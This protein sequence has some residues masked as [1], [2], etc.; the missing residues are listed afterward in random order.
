MERE[1]TPVSISVI[2]SVAS[3][4]QRDDLYAAVRSI[5][6]QSVEDFEFQIC[7]SEN[8]HNALC[9][10]RDM[11]READGWP[12]QTLAKYYGVRSIKGY[13]EEDRIV[14]AAVEAAKQ[15]NA[16]FE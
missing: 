16:K 3:R 15:S 7:Y 11:V 4:P 9:D 5:L 13:K 12:N 14:L 6:G 8:R 1:Q 10:L 2:M